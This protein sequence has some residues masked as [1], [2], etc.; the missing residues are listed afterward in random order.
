ML[1]AAVA[2]PRVLA[3]TPRVYSPAIRDSKRV[4]EVEPPAK[5]GGRGGDCG[6]DDAAQRLDQPGLNLPFDSTVAQST[7]LGAAP[8][9]DGTIFRHAH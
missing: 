9:E 8:R 3:G 1:G 4:R 7:H 6:Y 5:V 2:Q